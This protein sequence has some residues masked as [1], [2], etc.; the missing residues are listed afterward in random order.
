MF[1]AAVPALLLPLF[2]S[3]QVSSTDRTITVTASRNSNVT[4]D[5]ASISVAVYSN[6][7]ASRDDVLNAAQGSPLT[8]ATFSS[9]YSTTLYDNNGRTNHDVL[10]WTFAITAP[11]SNLKSTI[12]QLTALQQAVAAKNNGMSVSYSVRGTQTS[13]QALAGQN[14][15]AADLIADA[16]SQ[17]QKLASAAGLS[18]G[19]VVGVSGA[20]VV[21]PATGGFSSGISQ[22]SCSLTVKF[23]LTGV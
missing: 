12:D 14:C 19:N 16:R 23:A 11:I 18:V 4:P 10:E 8:L 6:T 7:D 2:L 15:A 3:A 20:S 5:Q 22:P 9:V 1:K 13:P 17:A 21:T